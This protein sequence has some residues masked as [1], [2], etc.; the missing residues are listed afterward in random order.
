MVDLQGCLR[1]EKR[2]WDAFVEQAAPIIFAAVQRTLQQYK[3][4][5]DATEAQDLAQ[6]VF[7]RLVERDY[8][9]LRTY[10]PSR[11]S[12]S[13][14]LTL[15]AR[16]TT[17][18]HLRRLKPRTVPLDEAQELAARETA[19]D[20]SPPELD[21]PAD[22]LSPRQHLILKLLFEREMSVEEAAATLRVDP[23]TIRSTKHKAITRLRAFFGAR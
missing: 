6:D 19:P 15:V 23:Q 14:W 21:I 2:A 5:V 22:L 4:T 16:S 3:P 7:V 12:L 13:T 1:G 11:A 10:D 17:I 9:L 20:D 8:R 18:D